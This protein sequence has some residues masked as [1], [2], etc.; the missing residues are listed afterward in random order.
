MTD[1]HTYSDSTGRPRETSR[2]SLEDALKQAFSPATKDEATP[3]ADA[4]DAAE[5]VPTEE[6]AP[7][8]AK[9]IPPLDPR[10]IACLHRDNCQY[11]PYGKTCYGK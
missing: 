5:L 1:V 6:A 9:P 10:C 2:P 4:T 11:R 8:D 7:S 3:S